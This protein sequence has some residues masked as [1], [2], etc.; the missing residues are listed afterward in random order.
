MGL[1]WHRDAQ[2][3][4][5]SIADGVPWRDDLDIPPVPHIDPVPEG[6]PRPFWSVMIPIY[7]CAEYLRDTL[8]SVLCQDPGAEQMQIEVIDNCSDDDPEAVVREIGKGRIDF[9]RQSRNVGAIENFN[10]CIRRA[11]GEWVH[12]LHG[13]DT[14]RPGLYS[15]ARQGI[16]AYPHVGGAVCRTIYMDGNGHWMGLTELEAGTP[17][18]L[19]GDFAAR[20][21]RD[22]R[23]FFVGM[24]VRR[25]VYEE[26]GGFRAE[27]VHATDWDM[28][29]RIAVHR[30]IFYDPEPLACYRLHDAADTSRLMRTGRNVVDERRS[31]RIACTY[32]P[33]EQARKVYRDAM[34]AAAV[35]AIGRAMRLWK[36][37]KHA[38]AWRQFWEAMRCSLAPE[39]I[40]RLVYFLARTIT[41]WGYR[42]TPQPMSAQLRDIG[43]IDSFRH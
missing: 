9:Y 6:T 7:N 19:D 29:K 21:L 11:R 13:D 38:V 24:L 43:A 39:I 36:E 42:R 14:V 31:I 18:V 40:A 30:P 34:K 23:I 16:A 17:G 26:L 12:I 27:L 8:Q 25:S 1:N 3:H 5:R 35:R 10:T 4:R 41:S 20:L 2:L 32:V 15:R 22:Q 28:W 33:Q 37:G